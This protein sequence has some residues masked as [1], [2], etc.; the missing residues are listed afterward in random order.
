VSVAATRQN[1]G[2]RVNASPFPAPLGG[3]NA[4]AATV[5]TAVIVVFARRKGDRLSHGVEANAAWSHIADAR[6]AADKTLI[7]HFI[8][9]PPRACRRAARCKGPEK[10]RA[11]ASQ[12]EESPTRSS[13]KVYAHARS[14]RFRET[15]LTRGE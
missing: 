12:D 2:S 7:G 14:N 6:T 1:D 15:A 8:V 4:P 5:W 3:M 11:V 9:I 10:G 13:S